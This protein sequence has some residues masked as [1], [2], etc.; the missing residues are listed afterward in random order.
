MSDLKLAQNQIEEV[1]STELIRRRAAQIFARTQKGEGHFSYH[2]EKWP[3]AVDFL[4]QVI[5]KNYPELRI[6]FHSRW[7]HFSVGGFDRRAQLKAK[8]SSLDPI[9]QCRI[10]YDLVVT[11]VLLDAGAGADW[12]Y[13]EASTGKTWRR[14]EGLGVA[15]FDWFLS[16]QMSS[17]AGVI[18]ADAEGLARLSLADLEKAFQVSAENPLLGAQGRLDLL[19]NLAS[20]VQQKSIF[21][22]PRPGALVDYL[23]QKYGS[24]IPAVGLL[25]AVL[26]GFGPIWPG[27]LSSGGVNLGDVWVHSGLGSPGT[28]ESLVP[29]HKLSQWLTYS[30]IEPLESA[31]FKVIGVEELTGLAE[32][33]NGGFFLD[34][35]VLS[36]KEAKEV[37][38]AHEPRSELIIEWRALTVHLLDKIAKDVQKALGFTPEAFPLAR[39][40]EGGTWWAGRA[41]A[42]KKR[43][44]ATPPLQIVSDGTVF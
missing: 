21:Q 39:V 35:G 31:G 8:I 10:E 14:S 36:L 32:Y 3:E 28:F 11:S 33:R 37:Q 17:Q 44:G 27:R 24:V 30:L 26:L 6:P 9:E 4:I 34:S 12:S 23:V 19:R 13:Q 5:R 15:S 1:F 43:P 7:R 38:V 2:S 22:E 41:W 40:L 25:K 16:G 18:K 20:A 42:E 29:F